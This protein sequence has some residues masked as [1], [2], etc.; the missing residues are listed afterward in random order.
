MVPVAFFKVCGQSNVAFSCCLASDCGLIDDV[1]LEA[2]SLQWAVRLFPTVAG[3]RLRCCCICNS[4]NGEWTS[5]FND[6]F[7]TRRV[8]ASA[9]FRGLNMQLLQSLN[10]L[11]M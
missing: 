1:S 6:L 3:V 2:F 10:R 4:H 7:K 9:F 11:I 5:V 8:S